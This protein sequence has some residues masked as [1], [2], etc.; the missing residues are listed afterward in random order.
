LNGAGVTYEV[1]VFGAHPDDAEMGMGGTIA[2]L[3]NAGRRVLIVSL[4]R[5]EQG[6]H[7][8]Q[9]SRERE[10]A[11]AAAILGCEH[12]L[13]DFPDTRV[14][15]DFDARAL[16]MR[17]V[18]ELQPQIVFAPYHTSRF[19]HHD[20]AAHVDHLATGA[21]VRDAIKLARIRGVESKLPAHDVRRTLYYM[22]PRDQYPALLVD[23]SAHMETLVRALH[24]Y[25]TQMR[26]ERQ[27]NS[28]ETILEAYRRYHGI[29]AGCTH[30]EAFLVEEALRAD[31]DTL[32]RL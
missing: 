19:G 7:G 15:N 9:Q 31:A 28:I 2:A 1:V 17:L 30:A 26:I 25:E 8:T 18:R 5:G 6:S 22:V 27:G 10:S 32:F 3:C 11:A 12:R 4:T 20:G 16:L 13:L 29:A 14:S 21:L 24:A 23:V